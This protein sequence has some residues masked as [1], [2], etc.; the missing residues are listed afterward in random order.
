MTISFP[1]GIRVSAL[2]AIASAVILSAA[3]GSAQTYL[4]QIA[5]GGN[6]YTAILLNNTTISAGTVSINFFQDTSNGATSPWN[7]P[8]GEVSSTQNLSV[9]AGGVLYIHTAGTAAT[10]T[11]GWGLVTGSPGVTAT[12][13]YTYESFA[14]RPNQDGTSQAVAGATRILVPFDATTGYSTGLAVV[15]PTGSAENI[16]VNIELDS[17]TISQSSLPSLPAGGQTAFSIAAQFPATAGHR[18]QAEFYVS[19]GSIAI[20]AFRINPTLALTSLPVDLASG[21]PII[22]A[23]GSG[24]GGSLPQFNDINVVLTS[25]AG[26]PVAGSMQIISQAGGGYSEVIIGFSDLTGPPGH[27]S[28]I[29][30]FLSITISGYTFSATVPQTGNS[31]YITEDFTNSAIT[32]GSLTIT[33]S[34]QAGPS[35]GSVNGSVNLVSGLATISGPLAGTYTAQ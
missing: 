32:S 11:Q 30:A 14:G 28:A 5:D 6:W 7:P 4:P 19:S 10:L 31:C 27:F 23:G 29:C 22:G 34:P 25:V 12:A 8:F 1:N 9:P 17:G 13:I 33:F 3:V 21:P 16:S 24:R 35:V 15:N 20:A 18:G 2:S 26:A